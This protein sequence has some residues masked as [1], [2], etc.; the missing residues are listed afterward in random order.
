LNTPKIIAFIPFPDN[1]ILPLFEKRT[2]PISYQSIKNFGELSEEQVCEIVEDA[3]VIVSMLEPSITKKVFESAKKLEFLQCIGVGYNQIDLKAADLHGI[4]VSNNPGFNSISVAEH[5]IMLILM[6]LKNI[7]YANK[8]SLKGL[9]MADRLKLVNKT[10]ELR[11]KT[12]GIIGLGSIG[13]EVAKLA[14]AFN[15]K[16]LYHKRNRLP[17][18]LE[19]T[20]GV[21]YRSLEELLKESD[22]VSIHTPLTDETLGLIGVEEIALMKP[23]AIIIN[24]AREGI[25]DEAAAALALN[26]GRLAGVGVDVIYTKVVD[27]V[28]YADSPLFGCENVVYTPHQSGGSKEAIVRAHQQW[29]DNVCR[30]LNGEKPQNIVNGF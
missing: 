16:I 28:I 15:A 27:N 26:E 7:L 22:I 25:L 12:L 5:T 3:T 17:I 24:T 21:E 30:F 18:T 8:E 6:T 20:L 29:T 10:L 1:R 9:H 2:R 14:K 13:K 23:S 11:D 4:P 19:K